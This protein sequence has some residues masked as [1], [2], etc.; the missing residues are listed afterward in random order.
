[1]TAQLIDGNA[2]SK[3]IRE[4]LVEEITIL[5]KQG[6]KPGLA[7]VLVGEDPASKIY[8][9][10]KAKTCEQL[11][12]YSEVHSLSSDTNQS[13]LLDLIQKLN[14]D[15]NIHGILVQLPLPK[16]ISE[17]EIIEAI[18][19]H[20][21]VDGFHPVNVGKL[22]IG[23]SSLLP[24]TPAGV[25]ELLKRSGITISGKHA[26]IIGRSN[27]VG[28]PVSL[29]LQ[30]E[31]AT[32]TM[33]HSRTTNMESIASQAD[34]L[35]VAT[36]KANMINQNFIKPGCTVID[37]GINRLQDGTLVGDVN[38]ND[39][40]EIAGY[41]TPV[42]GGVGPMTIAMLMKN[43]LEAAKNAFELR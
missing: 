6:L 19:V 37:V 40:K 18:A 27:I 36:G 7:V 35:V 25:I 26:V 31:D 22:V 5:K 12:V 23:E 39:V 16:H 33:C 13:R 17:K 29:L 32:V 20:K 38:F 2:I 8:V 43:T 42:P 1:M 4:E 11:G 9:G 24:C 15:Q 14:A 34:I 21:D 41:I 10:K 3:L 30:R 28:K